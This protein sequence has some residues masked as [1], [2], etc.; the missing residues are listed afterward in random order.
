MSGG[1]HQNTLGTLYDFTRYVHPSGIYENSNIPFAVDAG[2]TIGSWKGF[3]L[4]IFG[5]YA[6]ANDWLM[7]VDM[8]QGCC[9]FSQVNLKGWHF[10]TVATY[11]YRDMAKLEVGCETAPQK[12][13]RG[14]YLWRDRARHVVDASLTVTPVKALDITLG[15]ELRADRK[16][17]NPADVESPAWNL[18][19]AD[20]LSLGGLYRFTPQLS[21]FA[22]LENMLNS[23]H[24]LI[25]DIPAQGF[26]GLVGFGYKF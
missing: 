4:E 13:N 5:G 1:E 9:G 3:S 19:D 24:M 20:N 25:G 15:Y 8:M 23:K 14:Y 7:P 26:T 11:E 6:V 2:I 21:L 17:M 12:F 22:R 18:G 10:G 16:M